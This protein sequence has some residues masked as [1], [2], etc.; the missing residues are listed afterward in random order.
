MSLDT[1]TI[2]ANEAR[3]TELRLKIYGLKGQMQAS[4]VAM[5]K[6]NS[7]NNDALISYNNANLEL[8]ALEI[9]MGPGIT[10]DFGSKSPITQ[11]LEVER[12]AAKSACIDHVKGNPTSTE[13]EVAE[14][15]DLAALA[16]HPDIPYVLQPGLAM[17]RLFQI[18]LKLL[19]VIPN[20]D[21]VSQRAWILATPKDDIM[22]F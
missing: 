2:L 4:S 18:R 21:W 12:A 1:Q 14:A 22:Q 9:G 15:W 11:L 6:I 13:A 17:G 5:E 19:G 16:S 7:I 3:R 10:S 8:A 20:A